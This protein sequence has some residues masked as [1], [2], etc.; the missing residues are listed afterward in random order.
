MYYIE[1]VFIGLS[2][3]LPLQV[4]LIIIAFLILYIGPVLIKNRYLRRNNLTRDDAIDDRNLWILYPK[5]YSLLEK[6]MMVLI[7]LV[8]FILLI[9]A[10]NAKS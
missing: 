10:V 7:Y 1:E 2:K 5:Q 3:L 4:S 8:P 6:I 9:V